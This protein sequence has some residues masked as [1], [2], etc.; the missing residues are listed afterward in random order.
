M[1]RDPYQSILVN[2]F[3]LVSPITVLKTDNPTSV[4]TLFLSRKSRAPGTTVV[5]EL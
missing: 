2:E 4:V 1:P 5:I 3:D